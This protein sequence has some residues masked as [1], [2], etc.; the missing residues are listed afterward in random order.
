MI[1]PGRN[2]IGAGNGKTVLHSAVRGVSASLIAALI[3]TIA[4]T[5][6]AEGSKANPCNPNPCLNGGVCTPTENGALCACPSQFT[7]QDCDTPVDTG[8]STTV[9]TLTDDS[10]S[11]DT[12]CSLRKAINNANSPGVDTTGGDCA[13]ANAT[14]TITF[15]V[16]GTI[17]LTGTLPAIANGDNLT[18]DGTGEDITVDN[19]GS[20]EVLEVSSGATLTLNNLTIA[21]GNS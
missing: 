17:A 16:S 9:N 2:R 14:D 13:T 6:H 21:H 10:T 15:S 18:I 12:L 1:V 19:G 5:A 3:L 7:G 11:G 8:P 4:S 20:Y